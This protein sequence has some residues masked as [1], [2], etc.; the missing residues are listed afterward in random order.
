MAINPS[1]FNY[2]PF[3]SVGFT[4]GWLSK[5]FILEER[6]TAAVDGGAPA[7][8]WLPSHQGGAELPAGPSGIQQMEG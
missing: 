5:S 2:M 1:L 7:H 6:P 8:A 3:M 4:Q